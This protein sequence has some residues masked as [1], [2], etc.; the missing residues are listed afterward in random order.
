MPKS[1]RLKNNDYIANDYC[2]YINGREDLTCSPWRD[3]TLQLNTTNPYWDTNNSNN[4]ELTSTGIKC[5][6]K[7]IVL[8]I[9]VLSTSIRDAEFDLV[10][11]YGYNY[12][13]N[14]ANK[15]D[16]TIEPV[17]VNEIKSLIYVTGQSSFT[18][19]C[20]RLI[21]MRVA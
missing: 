15:H 17:N 1:I 9:R 7:G 16:V 8:V 18:L 10:D 11:R 4:F 13:I 14:G 5:K 2:V 12:M 6:F 20:S 21:I 3:T 19:Y